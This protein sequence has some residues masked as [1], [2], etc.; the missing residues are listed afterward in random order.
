MP[1]LPRYLD[2]VPAATLVYLAAVLLGRGATLGVLDWF[3]W[4][5]ATPALLNLR[6]LTSANL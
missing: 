1:P 6:D 5:A 3:Y 4:A 2:I